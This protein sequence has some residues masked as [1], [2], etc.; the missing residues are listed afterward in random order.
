M[1]NILM[2]EDRSLFSDFDLL[3]EQFFG[4]CANGGPCFAA[5]VQE[6][7]EGYVVS[8]AIPGITRE[9]IHV[10]VNGHILRIHAGH[11]Q[12]FEL[13]RSIDVKKIEAHFEDEV[14]EIFLPKKGMTENH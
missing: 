8:A 3:A 9:K 12:A 1:K 2:K 6:T 4:S 7:D 14:L 10:S 13:P 5:N 11:D